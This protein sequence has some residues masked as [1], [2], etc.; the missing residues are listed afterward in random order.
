[1]QDDATIGKISQILIDTFGARSID[2]RNSGV[3]PNHSVVSFVLPGEGRRQLNVFSNGVS[4]DDYK[5]IH[6]KDAI[7]LRLGASGSG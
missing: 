7:D 3:V 5:H 4:L 2:I 1:M 6:N